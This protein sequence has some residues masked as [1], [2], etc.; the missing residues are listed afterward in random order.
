MKIGPIL[1]LSLLALAGGLSA[2]ATP[3]GDRYGAG[4]TIVA[5]LGK[6]VT[7]GGVDETFEV[8][9]GG[10]RQVVNVR[11]ADRT[12]PILIYIHG[13]PGAVEMPF[14]W[15][16]QR[17]WEDFFT[18][19][20]W[21][22]RGA[23]RSYPLN[24]PKTLAST[25]TIDRY[26]DDTIELIELLR[27]RYGKRRVVLLG[28]S[29]GSVVGLSVAARRPDLLHAYVGMGQYIDPVAGEQASF[30]W[31]LA[32][33]RA[34]G[35]AQAVRELQAL[36]PY[37][38]DFAI[39]KIDAERK[40]AVHYGGLFA[41]RN[42]GQFYFDA[43]RLSPAY[44]AD[45]IKA[46]DEGSGYTVR[47]VEPLLAKASFADLRTLHCPVFMFE[48]RHDQLVPSAITAAWLD[49]LAAPQ[50]ATIWFEHSAHMMMVEEPG[51]M[52]AAL[53]DH[54]LPLARD[55]DAAQPAR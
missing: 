3:H 10:A 33:A 26:R 18:V 36:Q 4:R 55:G 28:H 29:W 32:R 16:F 42:S 7:P 2:Q 13:G 47:I 15:T 46:W 6:I 9:L 8:M 31:T 21:D 27:R 45:D 22:Q 17:P 34:D 52:L 54:V 5:G 48:G 50:K 1:S 35:N 51:H 23:N 37:P 25:L 30:A 11:G 43:A 19:V 53:I 38:G 20:Q 39:D 12:N 24:D 49:R 41:Y 14:A 40:W 44:T